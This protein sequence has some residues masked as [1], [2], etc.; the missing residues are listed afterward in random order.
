MGTWFGLIR[1]TRAASSGL[2]WAR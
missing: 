1:V 2:F